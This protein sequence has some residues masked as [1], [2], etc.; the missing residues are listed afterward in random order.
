MKDNNVNQSFPINENKMSKREKKDILKSIQAS[1]K[2]PYEQILKDRGKEISHLSKDIE[3]KIMNDDV[4]YNTPLYADQKKK[5]IDARTANSDTVKWASLKKKVSSMQNTAGETSFTAEAVDSAIIQSMASSGIDI[6]RDTYDMFDLYAQRLIAT[7]NSDSSMTL[8]NMAKHERFILFRYFY[9]TNPYVGRILD[10]HVEIILSKMRLQPPQNSPMIIR[11]FVMDFYN[12]IFDDLDLMS[13][14]KELVLQDFIYGEAYGVVDDYY[15]DQPYVLQDIDTLE[16]SNFIMSDEDFKFVKTIEE[17]YVEDPQKVS[18]KDRLKYLSKKFINFNPKY[19]GPDDFRVLKFFYISEYFKNEDIDYQAI[20]M[21]LSNGF[22]SLL[23]SEDG[24]DSNELEDIGYSKGMLELTKLADSTTSVIIDNDYTSGLPYLVNF[25][26]FEGSSLMYR[27]C[28]ACLEWD[29]AKKALKAKMNLLGKAGRVITSEGLS[30]PQLEDL[31]NQVM[32]M[33]EDPTYAI[34]ANY[35]INWQ[36]VNDFVKQELQDL[37]TANDKIK[38]EVADGLGMAV[39]LLSSD[40]PSQYSGDTIKIEIINNQYFAHKVKIQDLINKHFMK[41]IAMRKGLITINAW[42][43][44]TLI[45][46]KVA[47]S[48]TN[49]RSQEV[50]ESLFNLYQKGSVPVDIIYDVLNLDGDAVESALRKDAFTLKNDKANEAIGGIFQSVSDEII[51]R[52]DVVNK[53][54]KSFGL[55]LKEDNNKEPSDNSGGFGGG[56]DNDFGGFGGGDMGSPDMGGDID[57]APPPTENTE[58]PE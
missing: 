49:L 18:V 24:I 34:V 16:E 51:S 28:D 30:E 26:K 44:P 12:K 19:R 42:G 20:R 22:R 43:V 57:S 45:Y 58:I 37:M 6:N 14:F 35:S 1:L 48:L 25:S 40:Q 21:E 31:N 56:F 39:S 17:R 2:A 15:R 54:A 13:K 53:I 4:L 27:V 46:P 11:D 9:R 32:N 8:A 33:M 47:F 29:A 5:A 52:S 38:S 7:L 55:T 3:Q 23:E 41:P 36:E 50:F 10:L